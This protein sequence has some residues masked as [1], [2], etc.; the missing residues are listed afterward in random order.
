[1]SEAVRRGDLTIDLADLGLE[2]LSSAIGQLTQLQCLYLGNNQLTALPKAIGQLTQLKCLSLD[3]NQLTALPKAIGQLTQLKWLSLANNQLTALPK[4]IGQL[5]QLQR[6]FH[7]KNQLT[8]LPEAIGQLTQ[9]QGLFLDKNQL[10]ALPKAIG[11]LTQLQRLSLAKNQLTALP[12]A[13]GQLTQLQCLSLGN[14]QLTALPEAIGQ[15]TQLQW[16]YLSHNRLTGLPDCLR[17]LKTLSEL[18]LH[19][20][21]ALGLPPEI[22]GPT[23]DEVCQQRVNPAEPAQILDYYFRTRQAHRPLNEAK[24][25]LVGR[26]GVGKT[27]LVN[28]LVRNTFDRQQSR[29][30]G[31]QITDWP[32]PLAGGDEV[33]LHLWD[34][35][36]QEIMHATHQFF[37]TQR[38]LYLLVLS[39]REGNEDLEAE[40]WLRIIESFGAESPVIVVLNKI[41]E[42]PFEVNRRALQAKY[43]GIRE[44]LKTDCADRTGIDDLHAAVRRETDRLPNLRVPFPAG[45]FTIKNELSGSKKNFLSYAEY[46]DLCRTHGEADP[47]GQD[48]LAGHLHVLG[49]ALNFK[50]DP[51]LQDTHVL[52]PRWV[53]TGVY[54]LLNAPLL[55]ERK[56]ILCLA[57]VARLLN[58][59]ATPARCTASCS[60]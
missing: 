58:P 10:T 34:F 39:G 41:R 5:T 49:I 33:R 59:G 35:G 46:R 56:G 40:Y 42:M 28:R 23:W 24:L 31:I 27:C 26:G 2:E 47:E 32:V 25:I 12:K 21:P 29:T 43:P 53:T 7:D 22:L 15:L 38:G 54:T 17:P 3:N 1:M 50:D 55:A 11:Q 60:T 4:A 37:L 9:L 30:H 51:R 16:L 20:N 57:D 48:A 8:A 13:I 45:W 36:G 52:N 18:Y 19:D 14:N 6:L 44:F